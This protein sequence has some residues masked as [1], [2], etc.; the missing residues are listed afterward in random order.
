MKVTATLRHLRIS[1]RKV[2]LVAAI[3]RG[4]N[5]EDA[6]A[7]LRFTPKRAAYPLLKL[8]NSAV[9]NAEHNFS[10]DSTGLRIASITVDGGPILK[11]F[12]PKG[13]GRAARIEHRTSHIRLELEGTKKLKKS[14]RTRTLEET[15]EEKAAA[16]ESQKQV[17]EREFSV[18][19]KIGAERK[20]SLAKRFFRRKSV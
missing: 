16:E 13:F 8:L 3:M 15:S 20:P 17:R 7:T 19:K 5:V 12:R 14:A 10:L 1:P 6:R 4:R 9:A 18:E 11:R 2:R